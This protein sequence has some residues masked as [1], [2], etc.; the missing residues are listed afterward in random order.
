MDEVVENTLMIVGTLG[1]RVFVPMT[2]KTDQNVSDENSTYLYLKRKTKKSNRMIE[3]ICEQ[4]SEGFV[5]LEGSQVDEVDSPAIPASLKELRKE[6]IKS[7]VIKN[8]VLQEKQLFSSPSYAAA[9]VLGMNTN[10][11]TD[12]KN[13]DGKTLKELEEIMDC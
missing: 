3:A 7:N 12:W 8:G 10:G 4:T 11:R 13:K 9:F 2:K 5:V 1:Y 6:L